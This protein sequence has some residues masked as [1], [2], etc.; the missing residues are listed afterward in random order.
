MKRDPAGFPLSFELLAKDAIAFEE[1]AEQCRRDKMPSE[2]VNRPAG[3][4]GGVSGNAGAP[5]KE[6]A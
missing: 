5:A 1:G 3:R 4:R 2:P 6:R